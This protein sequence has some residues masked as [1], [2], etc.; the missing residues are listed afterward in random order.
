MGVPDFEFE[1]YLKNMSSSYNDSYF[2]PYGVV[3][4]KN[5]IIKIMNDPS[6]HKKYFV[7]DHSGVCK[8]KEIRNKKVFYKSLY[9]SNC[10][11]IAKFKEVK[12]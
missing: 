9:G 4:L 7:L 10:I 6:Y 3:R 1:T 5:S 12:S 2:N 8:F 11:S